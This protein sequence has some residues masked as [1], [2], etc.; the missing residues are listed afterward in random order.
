MPWEGRMVLR[1]EMYRLFNLK[2]QRFSPNKTRAY[3]LLPDKRLEHVVM[4]F[5][6][7][8]SFLLPLLSESPSSPAF[9]VSVRGHRI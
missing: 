5:S 1:V 6:Q 2:R 4:R 9:P 3:L 7:C 8:P